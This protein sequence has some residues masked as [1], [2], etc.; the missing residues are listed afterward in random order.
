MFWPN[1]SL[2]VA[3]RSS[4]ADCKMRMLVGVGGVHVGVRLCG[5]VGVRVFS[6]VGVED[7]LCFERHLLRKVATPLHVFLGTL[8]QEDG[9]LVRGVHIG[10]ELKAAAG[11]LEGRGV[12]EE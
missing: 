10:P 7:V 1:S 8:H 5:R 11:G 9:G 3:L 4:D 2:V 12:L 6:S